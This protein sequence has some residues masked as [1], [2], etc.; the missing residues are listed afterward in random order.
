MANPSTPPSFPPT[1]ERVLPPGAGGGAQNPSTPPSFPPTPATSGGG[2]ATLPGVPAINRNQFIKNYAALVARTWVDPSFLQLL[3]SDPVTTLANA[4]I[5]TVAGAEVVV[6]QGSITGVGKV[7]DAL[8]EWI[9][10]NTTGRYLLWIPM[11][12]DNVDL[13]T[14][15]GGA[16]SPVGG[17]AQAD[18][19]CSCC[20]CCC[21]T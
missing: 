6:V 4:G 14:G 17:V 2:V 7:E 10:G 11:K 21:C 12:P 16:G 9:K 5:P 15:P 3:L 18:A 8:E 20:P 1:P 13:P 19:C